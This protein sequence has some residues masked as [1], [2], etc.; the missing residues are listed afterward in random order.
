MRSETTGNL[1]SVKMLG[2][3]GWA[4]G[5]FPREPEDVYVPKVRRAC[6]NAGLTFEYQRTTAV[7]C[8]TWLRGDFWNPTY[9]QKVQRE[10]HGA[11]FDLGNVPWFDHAWE[12]QNLLLNKCYQNE[13][14]V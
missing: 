7:E 3:W 13:Y 8:T 9:S 5:S 11:K 14:L 12:K 4:N 6:E 1:Q 10:L 2:M